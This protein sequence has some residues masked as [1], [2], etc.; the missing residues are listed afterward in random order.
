MKIT[1]RQTPTKLIIP[2]RTSA[3]RCNLQVVEIYKLVK[4]ASRR[5]RKKKLVNTKSAGEICKW[6]KQKE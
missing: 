6:V 2:H 3:D 4:F 1:C 5:N